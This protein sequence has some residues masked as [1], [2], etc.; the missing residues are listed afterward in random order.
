MLSLFSEFILVYLYVMIHRKGS[1]W[2]DSRAL[3]P[4]VI[5]EMCHD[6]AVVL[7]THV[8]LNNVSSLSKDI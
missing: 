1:I 8:H 4:E 5:K 2:V 7:V 6:S 3:L